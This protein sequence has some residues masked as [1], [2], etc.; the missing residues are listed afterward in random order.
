VPYG[1]LDIPADQ[2]QVPAVLDIAG[3]GHLLIAGSARSGRSTA[4]RTIA[5]SIARSCSP[6]DVHLYGLD[7]GNGALLPLADLPH[8]GV[9][10]SRSETGRIERLIGRLNDEVTRRQELFALQGFGDIAEQRRQATPDGRLPYIVVLLD[11]WEGFTGTFPPEAA[12]DV[13]PAL[14]KLVREGPGAGVRV[15]VAGDR[16]IVTDRIAAQIE[17]RLVMR[18]S[19]KND[20]RLVNINP[21]HVPE[22]MPPG[23][24]LTAERGLEIQIALLAP[25]PAGQAQAEAVRAIGRD[26]DARWPKAGRTAR[27]L[28]VDVMPRVVPFAEA[29]ALAAEI[30]NDSPLWALAGIGGDELVAF[31][32]DLATNGPGFVIAG[33]SKSGRSTALAAIGRG[34]LA[35]GATVVVWCPRTSPLEAFEGADGVRAVIRGVPTPDELRPLLE[36]PE[37]ALAVLVDD[38]S[39]IAR[40]DADEVLREVMRE[41]GPGRLA[42]VVAGELDE[43][44][45]ELR[46]T[47][48]EA[49]KAK[50]GLL[51]SP[52]SSLDGDVVGVRLNR[53]QIG[54]LGAGRGWFAQQGETTLVQVPLV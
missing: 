40:S 29:W 5:G 31:G 4:L 47:I 6:S 48:V 27:P 30:R 32:V 34:F 2:K 26:A 9:V 25:D 37:G 23:R 11:R 24:A 41:R 38:A 22:I 28:R 44:K 52:P 39:A 43:L 49:R 15:V 53:S 10:V 46:G 12:S 8:T 45:N 1:R 33:P 42:V 54:K 51:L 36:Q 14:M 7:F 16:S 21:K 3:G 19:E 50:L 20:Y 17:D 13:P 18:L 35:N